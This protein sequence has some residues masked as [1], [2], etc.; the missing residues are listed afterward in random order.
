[1]SFGPEARSRRRLTRAEIE[2]PIMRL[3][4]HVRLVSVIV[5]L[6]ETRSPAVTPY[7]VGSVPES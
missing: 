5:S 4:L 6:C 1:M 3:G 7:A 2:S